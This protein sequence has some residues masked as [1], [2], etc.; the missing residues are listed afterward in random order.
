MLSKVSKLQQD[1][2]QCLTRV[3]GVGFALNKAEK[4][5]YENRDFGV[6]TR[7]LFTDMMRTEKIQ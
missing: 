6:L 1:A 7:V 5:T 4:H 3:N 2:S